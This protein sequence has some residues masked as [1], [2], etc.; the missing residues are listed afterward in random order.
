MKES[1]LGSTSNGNPERFTHL[2]MNYFDV[3]G[4]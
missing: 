2:K 3:F 4:A 1:Q